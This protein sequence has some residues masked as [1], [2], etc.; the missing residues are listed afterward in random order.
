MKKNSL[1]YQKMKLSVKNI[2]DIMFD[3]KT[4]YKKLS[5]K[6]EEIVS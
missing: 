1:E 4:N 3:H 2:N 5:N 6:I